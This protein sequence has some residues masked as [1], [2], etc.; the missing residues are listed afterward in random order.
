MTPRIVTSLSALALS[1]V[2]SGCG[3][4]TTDELLARADSYV[5]AQNI[6]A[7][8]IDL[9]TAAQQEPKNAKV[10]VALGR[11]YLQLGDAVSA[12][13]EFTKAIELGALNQEIA[14]D[15]IRA[16]YL[17]GV[18]STEDITQNLDL[19][20]YHGQLVKTYQAMISFD[21]GESAQLSEKFE[22]LAA[23]SFGDVQALSKAYLAVI[24]KDVALGLSEL[25]KITPE[26]FLYTDSLM[27]RARS[28]IALGKLKEAAVSVKQYVKNVPLSN[29]AKLFLAELL[30]RD[31]QMAEA[32]PI[33]TDFLKRF[34][35]QPLANHFMAMVAFSEKDN[36]LAKEYAEKSINNGFDSV[37]S[38]IIAAISSISQNLNAQALNHLRAVKDQLHAYPPIE[39]A[40][41]MLELQAGNSDLASQILKNQ[42]YT[43]Q[44]LNLLSSAAFELTRQGQANTA[45]DL[46]QHVEQNLEH[47]GQT[48]AS[49]GSLKMQIG[50]DQKDAIGDLEAALLK[51]PEEQ[52]AKVA[53][54]SAYLASKTY[55]KLAQLTASWKTNPKDAGLAHTFDAYSLFEQGKYNDVAAQLDQALA[56]DSQNQVAA[57]LYARLSL[58]QKNIVDAQKWV[59]QALQAKP[60]FIPALELNYW[61]AKK[62]DTQAQVVSQVEALVA[63]N[64]TNLP[65]QVLMGKIYL[66]Q[67]AFSKVEGLF[68]KSSPATAERPDVVWQL[69]LSAQQ[70]LGELKTTLALAQEWSNVAPKNSQAMLALARAYIINQQLQPALQVVK[71]LRKQDPANNNFAAMEVRLQAELGNPAEALAIMNSMPSSIQEAPG[72]A[73]MRARLLAMQGKSK[74]AISLLRQSYVKDKN[75]QSTI[76]LATL[77]AQHESAATAIKFLETHFATEP[78]TLRLQALYANLLLEQEPSK[79]E[80]SFEALLKEDGENVL[81]LNNLAYLYIQSNKLDQALGLAKRAIQVS[82]RNPDVLDTYGSVLLKKNDYD[83]AVQQFQLSLKIRPNHPEVTLNLA[84]ALAKAGKKSEAAK[85]LTGL[86]NVPTAL[87]SRLE[88]LKALVK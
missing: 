10:R 45:K 27:L 58:Q 14:P 70:Q 21:Q 13:K 2:L 35:E 43:E 24:Q 54:A 62:Q 86:Q 23:S 66:D 61:I 48:L 36:H 81:A 60:D 22:S 87:S 79:A 7:A 67:G 32:K 63:S 65:L 69:L 41:A 31:N 72:T 44:D 71:N 88:Q 29:T 5:K 1:L 76:A 59:T 11:A 74:D 47:N 37:N 84:E 12:S 57:L 16:E 20:S 75:E 80:Q 18:T 73:F 34:P 9:K 30:V 46:I 38:R 28:Q 68:S 77:L 49:L 83:N 78:K 25:E 56:I 40:Y 42:Q 53:L 52:S 6:S 33:L 55:D 19:A 17:A 26:S 4:K 85:L 15:R 51:M 39:K 3:Q 82:P 8:V 64:P 50:L